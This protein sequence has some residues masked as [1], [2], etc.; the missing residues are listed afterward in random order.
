VKRGITTL[1]KNGLWLQKGSTKC[2]HRRAESS[3]VYDVEMLRAL[4]GCEEVLGNT[5]HIPFL[6]CPLE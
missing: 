5:I 4:L 6:P 1:M 2:P 3:S